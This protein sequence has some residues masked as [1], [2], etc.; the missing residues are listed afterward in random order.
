MSKRLSLDQLFDR[1][2]DAA[3]KAKSRAPGAGVELLAADDALRARCRRTKGGS[4]RGM[5]AGPRALAIR[6]TIKRDPETAAEYAQYL[7]EEVLVPEV[8]NRCAED[9]GTTT[10]AQRKARAFL[11]L[12]RGAVRLEEASYRGRSAIEKKAAGK[13]VILFHGTTTKLIP[14]ILKR[15]LVIGEAKVDPDETPGVYLSARHSSGSGFAHALG[16][17]RRAA[18][19]LGGEPVVL[20]VRVPF[21]SLSWDSDDAD[22]AS[23]NYQFVT[24]E[25]PLSSIIA[26]D[27]EPVRG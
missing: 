7:E 18:G 22:I 6:E 14:K 23:G 26:V 2:M 16:Y 8:K 20:T 17:A 11:K 5:H 13:D 3:A 10:A 1:A 4:Y 19:R 24:D 25:V 21:D 27:D 9:E 15:G 12:A